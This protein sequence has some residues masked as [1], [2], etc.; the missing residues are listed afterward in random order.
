MRK[1]GKKEKIFSVKGGRY[2]KT[3]SKAQFIHKAVY[4]VIEPKYQLSSTKP[5]RKQYLSSK[6]NSFL[7]LLKLSKKEEGDDDNNLAKTKRSHHSDK[8]IG[9][10][11][12]IEERKEENED[13]KESN[14]K[15]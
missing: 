1:E 12:K 6:D 9:K 11:E 5:L 10:N 14:Y 15:K 7:S 2:K 13:E 8:L 3:F 4:K